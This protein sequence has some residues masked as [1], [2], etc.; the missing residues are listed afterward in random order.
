MKN[1]SGKKKISN[2]DVI[3]IVQPFLEDDLK[4]SDALEIDGKLF[5]SRL[6]MGTA[7]FPNIDVLNKSIEISESE[8][9]TTSIRRLGSNQKDFFFDQIKKD[10]TF[11]PNTAGCFTKKEALLT[12]ELARESMNTNWIKPE[13]IGEDEMLLP[14]P[15]ELYSTCE[16]LIKKKL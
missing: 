12:A 1:L 5:N 16:D 14:D 13:L 6:I 9:I 4:K 3:E 2:G 8:I 15:I 7:L 10:Y 11:L